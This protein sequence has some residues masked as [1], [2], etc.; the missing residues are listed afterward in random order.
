MSLLYS[1]KKGNEERDSSQYEETRQNQKQKSPLLNLNGSNISSDFH[2]DKRN[3]YYK[4]YSNEDGNSNILNI[5]GS[6]SSLSIDLNR[7]KINP[8]NFN[9]RKNNNKSY[10]NN[11]ANVDENFET[12]NPSKDQIILINKSNSNLNIKK[13][14]NIDNNESSNIYNSKNQINKNKQDIKS[15]NDTHPLLK[16]FNPYDIKIFLG[17]DF[18]PAKKNK[19]KKTIKLVNN[20]PPSVSNLQMILYN[21]KIEKEQNKNNPDFI[22][23]EFYQKESRR[24][25]A[26]YIKVLSLSNEN[27]SVNDIITNENINEIVLLKPIKE[28]SLNI[29]TN[30]IDNSFLTSNKKN[31]PFSILE[32][33]KA[34]SSNNFLNA[35]NS[36]KLVNNFL[37]DMNDESKDKISLIT[38]LSIPRIMNM[39]ISNNKKYS[40]IFYSSPT[41]ISCMYGIETYIFKW[42][43]CKN[44]SLMGYFDLINVENCFLDN[45]NKKIF[46]IILNESNTNENN[47]NIDEVNGKNNYS[48]EADDEETAL[49]Y[50][51]SINFISQLVKYRI[52]LRDKKKGNN[53]KI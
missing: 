48:I 7:F 21:K 19:A 29:T 20:I 38:F 14:N 15:N 49:G 33:S 36:F 24:M 18:S 46:N 11:N 13:G 44:F 17:E 26:E 34:E 4:N 41:N 5:N 30:H 8:N 10:V 37:K 39:I 23:K 2:S 32:M 53:R 45:D 9:K 51:N 50:V 3:M 31:E 40:F 28:K 42:N 25:M 35:P 6:Q 47:L 22:F 16:N 12:F 52:Y 1:I 43:E 27:L